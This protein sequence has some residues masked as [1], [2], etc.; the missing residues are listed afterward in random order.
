MNGVRTSWELTICLLQKAA[1][2]IFHRKQHWLVRCPDTTGFPIMRMTNLWWFVSDTP[3]A[4]TWF[5]P[6]NA[7]SLRAQWLSNKPT[8][9]PFVLGHGIDGSLW[10]HH[11]HGAWPARSLPK[12]KKTYYAV[13]QSS[14]VKSFWAIILIISRCWWNNIW[15]CLNT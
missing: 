15:I 12:T 11:L 8:L 3:C 2:C 10:C 7:R 4:T 14:S 1:I 5:G 6:A 13:Y 9:K